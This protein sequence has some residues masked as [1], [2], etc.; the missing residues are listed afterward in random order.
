MVQIDSIFLTFVDKQSCPRDHAQAFSPAR[1]H[2]AFSNINISLELI[3][4]KS[5]VMEWLSCKKKRLLF[6]TVKT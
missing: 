2:F 5:T 1:N 3:S 6:S 4:R